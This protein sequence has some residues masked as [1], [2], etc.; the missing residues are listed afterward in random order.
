M[1]I[2]RRLLDLAAKHVKLALEA[3][4]IWTTR[5]RRE[6]IKLEVQAIR[7]ERDLLLEYRQAHS[8]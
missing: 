1:D 6:D 3:S 8:F 7:M 5:S 2:D 4:D